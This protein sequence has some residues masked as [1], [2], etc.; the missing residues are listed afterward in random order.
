MTQASGQGQ[1]RL[2]PSEIAFLPG[3]GGKLLSFN[4]SLSV[5]S[6]E[7]FLAALFQTSVSHR[8]QVPNIIFQST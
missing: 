2:N 5:S 1:T 3:L 7:N 8:R 4:Y 6:I